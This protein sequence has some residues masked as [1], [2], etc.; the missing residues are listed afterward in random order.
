M[1]QPDPRQHAIMNYRLQLQRAGQIARKEFMLSDR[2]YWPQIPLPREGRG[3]PMHPGPGG[4]RGVPQQIAYPPHHPSAPMPPS[5]RQRHPAQGPAQQQPMMAQGPPPVELAYDDEEDT[6]RGDLFDHLTPRDVSL[7]RYKQNHEWM[8]EILSS[9]YRMDQIALADLGLG[10]KGELSSLTE[11][12]FEAQG[13]E[14]LAGGPKKPHVGHLD[15]S[16]A[17]EF[18]KRVSDKV[19]ATNA[20]IAKM[21]EDHEKMVAKFEDGSVIKDAEQ[22]L[23]FAIQDT[24]PATWRLESQADDGEEVLGRWGQS[25]NKKVEDIVSRVEAV[26]GKRTEVVQDVRRIQDGGYIEPA[27]EPEPEPEPVLPPPA[28][29]VGELPAAGAGSVM[30]RQPSQAETP[31]SVLMG[32]DSDIDMGGT[33][34]GLLDQ[35]HTGFSSH[36]TPVNSFPTPQPQLSTIPSTAATPANVAAPSPQPAEPSGVAA[37]PQ[38]E[39]KPEDVAMEDADRAKEGMAT[40]PDQGTDSGDWVVVPQG[41]VSSAE[42][43]DI[44]A[45]ATV[46]ATDPVIPT[47]MSADPTNPPTDTGKPIS[48][49]P[50]PADETAAP[51]APDVDNNDFSSLG[52]LDNGAADLDDYKSPSL[53]GADV[54]LD[55]GLD[56]HMDVEDSAFGDAFHT[57]DRREDDNPVDGGL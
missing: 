12:I 39:S 22:E 18:R 41:G 29:V 31:H 30:S 15:K 13:V 19:K 45:M 40:T 57:V 36:S 14:A 26:L 50:T 34:A 1:V 7:D 10:L 49:A 54:A 43:P 17:N 23:R 16:L 32:A 47:S 48:A 55:G 28:A 51:D 8:E 4:A 38:D 5:K 35:M 53:G 33:A 21:K 56:M 9:P 27:P 44:A 3:Q 37:Q 42:P 25:Q 2:A 24:V 11:G 6:A 46:T 20:E 52:D